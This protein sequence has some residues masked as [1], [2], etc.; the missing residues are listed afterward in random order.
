MTL[1]NGGYVGKDNYERDDGLLFGKEDGIAEEY[2]RY[3]H[4]DGVE[5]NINGVATGENCNTANRSQKMETE[6]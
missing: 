1:K 6:L 2:C 4:T 3:S 5:T